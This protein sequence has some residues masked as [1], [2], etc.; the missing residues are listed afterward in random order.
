MNG[1]EDVENTSRK[2]QGVTLADYNFYYWIQSQQIIITLHF[3]FFTL[4]ILSRKLCNTGYYLTIKLLEK[5]KKIG[6]RQIPNFFFWFSS[7]QNVNWV[8][9]FPRVPHPQHTHSMIDD[10]INYE[11]LSLTKSSFQVE[12]TGMSRRVQNKRTSL[13]KKLF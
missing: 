12:D 6:S 5:Q 8:T 11:H 13:G 4:T 9:F 2:I 3:Q 1:S 7:L 10:F